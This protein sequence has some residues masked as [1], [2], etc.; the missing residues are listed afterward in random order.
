[1]VLRTTQKFVNWV[2]GLYF[3]GWL[4]WESGTS[5]EPESAGMTKEREIGMLQNNPEKDPLTEKLIDSGIAYKGSFLQ[6][7]KDTVKTP[8]GVSR[9]ESI[10]IIRAL[11]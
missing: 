5:V 6:V 2:S 9:P 7:H 3:L 11:P 4:K 10:S 1:M 8:D